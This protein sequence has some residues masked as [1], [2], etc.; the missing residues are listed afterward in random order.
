MRFFSLVL[1]IFV[2]SF[3]KADQALYQCTLK[4][5]C[6][7]LHKDQVVVFP[8]LAGPDKKEPKTVDLGVVRARV[9]GP[10]YLSLYLFDTR[11]SQTTWTK[12]HS[13]SL[14][15]DLEVALIIP[16][17]DTHSM[18]ANLRCEKQQP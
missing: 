17:D 5:H 10:S 12:T 2:G 11:H 13:N 15:N 7:A 16:E 4:I 18:V 6:S 9:Y 1:F 14:V 8:Y 3:S